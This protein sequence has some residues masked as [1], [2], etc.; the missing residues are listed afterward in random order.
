MSL[1]IRF[2]RIVKSI[3]G[4]AI[5]SLENPKLILEQN[6]RD[7][8][9]QV[10]KMNKNIA[11]VKANLIM[12]QKEE[13]KLKGK[14]AD[15]TSKI[16]ASIQNGREDLAQQFAMRLEPTRADLQKVTEQLVFANKAYDKALQVR[17]VFMRERENKI[18]QARDAMR[19]HERA[20]WQS[21]I[22]DTLE[23]FEVGGMD[24]T[25]EEMIDR[26]DEQTARNEAKM[27]LALDSV[28]MQAMQVDEDAQ[29]YNAAALV[30]Q[31]KMEM[32]LS[33][34]P[35]RVPPV[36]D[37]VPLGPDSRTMGRDRIS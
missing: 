16:K 25:H 14:A 36:A 29:Q 6:I 20:K 1:W 37:D 8:N 30:E 33:T 13:R 19:A 28:D 35:T 22:A 15:L 23:Q 31:M 5:S 4:G 17:K 12:L 27:E 32:G 9:E 2:K 18:N 10:P 24:N 7:L 34:P 26:L 21:Q 3:F 11:D